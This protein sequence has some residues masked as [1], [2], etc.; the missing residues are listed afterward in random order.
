LWF[1]WIGFYLAVFWALVY[2]QAELN[3]KFPIS[4]Q[5]LRRRKKEFYDWL[6]A[7]GRRL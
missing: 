2:R 1:F 4:S 6:A 3:K 7:R 5:E